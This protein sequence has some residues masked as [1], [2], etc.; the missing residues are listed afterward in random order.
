[1]PVP[2]VGAQVRGGTAVAVVVEAG[3]VEVGFGWI[4]NQVQAERVRAE[5]EIVG[6]RVPVQVQVQGRVQAG[7]EWV[8]D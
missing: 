7:T 3:E 1:M 8:R 4:L 2:V 5:I 6:D